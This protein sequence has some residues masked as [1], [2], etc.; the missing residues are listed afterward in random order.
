MWTRFDLYSARARAGFVSA[1]AVEVGVDEVTI[2]TD[3]GRVLL[4][5]EAEAER[6]VAAAQEPVVP[7]VV[8]LSDD[9]R[10]A[11]MGLLRDPDLIGRVA[12][13]LGAGGDRR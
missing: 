7:V 12:G 5:C 2:K 11:A 13:D 9:E 4:A 3:L 1:A 6:V 10:A 8:E